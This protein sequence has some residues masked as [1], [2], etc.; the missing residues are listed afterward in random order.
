[1]KPLPLYLT[2]AISGAS[3]LALEILGTRVLGP[4]YGNSLFLWSALITVTLA[5]LAIGYA[6]GGRWA[7]RGATPKRLGTILAV[8][9]VWVLLIPVL[10]KPLLMATEPMGLRAAV[11]AASVGLFFLPLL[12]MGMV[13]PY[14]IRLRLTRV[15]DAGRTAGDLYA[16]STLASVAGALLTGFV[17]IPELG[18]N[19]L[20]LSIGAALLLAAG[21]CYSQGGGRALAVLLLLAAPATAAAGW[22]VVRER[23]DH[24]RGLTA[25]AESNYAQLRVIDKD[26]LR[27]LI[28]DGGVHTMVYPGDWQTMHRYAMVT[29]TFTHLFAGRGRV[30][31]V[32]LGGGSVAKAYH[33]A[34]WDVSAVEID[35]MVT[36]FAHDFFG[37]DP[38]ETSVAHMD[39]RRFL[40]TT[41]E[42]YDLIVGDAYGSSSVPWQ[43]LTREYVAEMK[44]RL[45]EGGVVA[46]NLECVG[47]DD[48]LIRSA[49][50][51]LLTSFSTVRA[52]PTSEPPDALGNV[53]LL[54]ADRPIDIGDPVDV[55]GHPKDVAP[56]TYVHFALLQ[57][58]HAWDNAYVPDTQ[59]APV[60]TDDRTPVDLWAERINRVARKDLH[61][62]FAK[63]GTSW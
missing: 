53:M 18:V 33:A 29:E 24:D 1:M 32:G 28:I 50:A 34:G 40:R 35:P 62:Y 26:D 31:V 30:L 23:T 15:E 61:E 21:L 36:R 19:R 20:I 54:A 5:A 27:H 45:N 52:L 16:I 49:A 59:G 42:R 10:R 41:P 56:E 57:K 39:A 46:L 47:W 9:G 8:A 48:I 63:D 43:L 38:E 4:F 3:V 14:A 25:I 44:S 11:L 22:N 17:L 13:S 2:V 55:L 60:L 58:L 7:D 6:L 12:L 37:L 51:T